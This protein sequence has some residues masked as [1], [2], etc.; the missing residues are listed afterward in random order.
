MKTLRILGLVALLAL[1]PVVAMAGSININTADAEALADSLDGVGP[2]RAQAIVEYR[3]A[4][5]EFSSVDELLEVSGIGAATLESLRD[6][7]TVG[8]GE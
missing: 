7:V 4:N 1:A 6:R 5:G 2:V 8:E 3:E